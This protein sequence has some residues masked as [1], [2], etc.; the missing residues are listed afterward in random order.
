MSNWFEDNPIKSVIGH[1]IIVAS[2]TWVVSTFVLQDNRINLMR[3]EVDSQKAVA[4]QYKAKVELLQ[5]EIDTVRAENIEY[6]AWLSQ[7][8][9]AVP[10]IVPRITELKL[11][12]A[13]LEKIH[14]GVNASTTS[15][16]PEITIARG[17]AYVDTPTGLVFTVLGINHERQARIAIKLPGKSVAD[18]S[19]VYPGWQWKFNADGQ[20]HLLTLLEVNFFGDSIRIQITRA[21]E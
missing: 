13:E 11:K 12:I 7:S 18:E 16:S 6:R 4:E 1:T 2:F 5:R 10:T 8:K 14:K 15:S 20:Q 19:T 9:D 21:K 3:S 17:R